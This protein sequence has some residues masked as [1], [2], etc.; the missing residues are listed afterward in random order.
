[1]TIIPL[2]CVTLMWTHY[3]FQMKAWFLR[4][5][6]QLKAKNGKHDGEVDGHRYFEAPNGYGVLVKPEKLTLIA[7]GWE[8]MSGWERKMASKAIETAETIRKQE[9]AAE[10]REE[11]KRAK[12]QAKEKLV[13]RYQMPSR[14]L[15][16]LTDE[17]QA[18]KR[19]EV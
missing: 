1:M 10:R 2:K 13:S 7:A 14:G 18:Q 17:Q 19:A 15:T 8:R 16:E 6:V 11:E 12:K 9:A 4:V 3:L 5:G